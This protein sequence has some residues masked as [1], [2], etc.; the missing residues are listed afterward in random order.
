[1]A[2]RFEEHLRAFDRCTAYVEQMTGTLEVTGSLTQDSMSTHAQ[3]TLLQAFRDWH[4]GGNPVD[5]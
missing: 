5:P 2:A 4:L 3:A 1:M